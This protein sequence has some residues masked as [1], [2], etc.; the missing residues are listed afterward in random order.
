MR[1]VLHK[2]QAP[3][4]HR[5]LH[6]SIAIALVGASTAAVGGMMTAPAGASQGTLK[7]AAIAPLS[8][9]TATLGKLLEGPC[10]GAV[11]VVNAAG[12]VLG[13]H[14]TCFPV[15]DLGDPADAVANVSKALATNKNIV[16]ADGLTSATAA[17]E[18][19]ILNSAKV[20]M[21]SQNGLSIF[22]K[23]LYPYF[24]R[25]T[26]PDIDGGAALGL[27]AVHKGMK[28]VA[29][30]IQ[31]STANTGTRP[32]IVSALKNNHARIVSNL[33]IPG[34]AASYDSTINRIRSEKPDGLI[35]SADVQTTAAL[36]SEYSSLNN[37]SVPPVIVPTGILGTGFYK[38]V[39]K[40]M[41]VK[42]LTKNVTLVGTYVDQKGSAFRQYATAVKHTSIGAN[43]ASAILAT[44]AIGTVYDGI[45]VMSLAMNAAHSTSP[46]VYNKY[47]PKVTKVRKGAK[48][49]HSYA[50]GVHQLKQGH[51]IQYVGV[52]G[53]VAFDHFHTSSG[54]YA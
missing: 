18:V 23:H 45:V 4:L 34:D 29:I 36:L 31:N 37:G 53:P 22:T 47:M 19:P 24:W 48:V 3:A 1:T 10:A 33:L 5:V 11:D 12:G 49:V 13:H 46:A 40:L 21:I 32:G 44:E 35:I 43:E 52:T 27:G 28:K 17:T 42:Y 38:D 39:K 26:S 16:G 6:G 9:A 30:L 25:M 20:T 51:Q 54:E 14:L 8:G 2:H 15:N 41:G 7:I 50:Q